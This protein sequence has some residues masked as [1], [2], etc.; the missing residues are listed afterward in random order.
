MYVEIV[1]AAE[2]VLSSESDRSGA[3]LRPESRFSHGR[4]L[5]ALLGLGAGELAG[6]ETGGVVERAN[7]A[8]AG[9]PLTGLKGVG[10]PAL[11]DGGVGPAAPSI[12]AP[13]MA[14]GEPECL[15]V[16]LGLWGGVCIPP[17]PSMPT[18]AVRRFHSFPLLLGIVGR[19][20]A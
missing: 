8:L 12:A 7:R 9:R 19:G 14:A 4:I 16:V 5:C 1:D 6:E 2:A 17:I 18:G 13:I 10:D 20:P 11:L 15:A 3:A